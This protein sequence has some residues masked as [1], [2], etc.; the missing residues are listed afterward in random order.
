MSGWGDLVQQ[1]RKTLKPRELEELP[2]L[3]FCRPPAFLIAKGLARTVVTPDAV[4]IFAMFWS[5]LVAYS[6]G[7]GDYAWALVGAATYYFWNVLDCVDGQLARMK[8]QYSPIGY[9]LDMVVDQVSTV[10]FF[11]GMAVGLDAA[12]PG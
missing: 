6:Y 8:K 9:I 1:Y 2:D 11:V 10:L 7:R 5:V 12:R 4:S 3:L